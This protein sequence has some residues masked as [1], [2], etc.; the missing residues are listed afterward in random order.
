M[1]TETIQNDVELNETKTVPIKDLYDL[2]EQGLGEYEILTPDGFKPIGDVYKKTNKKIYQLELSNGMVLKGSSDHLVLIDTSRQSDENI[3]SNVELRDNNTWIRLQF[4]TENEFV[5]TENGVF[6]VSDITYIGNDD[7]F[8]LEVLTTEHSYISNGIVSHNT[9]KSAI[10]EGLAIR[11]I[12]KK[13]P[14][15][16]FDKRI[17]SLDLGTIVAGTK[18]RG[19]FE[20]RMKAI[21]DELV[22]NP[23][24]ILFIDEI[25]T[26]VGAGGTSGSLDAANMV[27]PALARGELQCIGATTIDE[28][29]ENIEKDGAL[30]RRFQKVDIDPTS[31]EDTYTIL[32]N[33]KGIYEDHHNV[34]YTDESLMACVKLSTRYITDRNLPDKAIDAMDEAGSRVNIS[35]VVVPKKITDLEEKID[36]LNI[37]KKEVVKKQR[38]EDAAKIRDN[39][40]TLKEELEAAKEEW[41][42]SLKDNKKTVNESDI[43]E[44]ISMVTGIPLKKV[45]SEEDDTLNKLS[46]RLKAKVVGQDKAIEKVSLAIKRSRIGLKDPNKPIGTFI[47]AGVSGSGKTQLS[48]AIAEELFEGRDSLIRVDMSEY[49]ER[50]AVSRLIGAP[51]GYVGH[52][53]GGKLTEAVRRKPYSVVL[54]DEIEK[55]HPDVFN[56]LLQV[57]DEGHLTDSLGRKV[58]FKNTIIIMTSNIGIKT[59]S[60]FGDGIGFNTDIKMSQ[61]EKNANKVIEKEM[62]KKFAPEFL[63]RID[64]IIIFNELQKSHLNEIVKIELKHVEDRINELG[65]TFT[66]RKK[67]IEFIAERGYNPEYGARPLKRAIQRYVEDPIAEYLVANNLKE[68]KITI[69]YNKGDEELSLDI[70]P[71][72]S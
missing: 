6:K 1:T 59:L 54:L 27:K 53:E 51:P 26:I 72:V 55:A 12:E 11:I 37:E 52:E 14:R 5:V 31:E 28:Y 69:N 15:V 22:N 19:E 24:I 46:D 70:K 60:Q 35:N 63:N 62:K 58:D 30:V 39:E 9:G 16:L 4:I 41:E 47:M 61:K 50:F 44:V 38:Y 66:I 43:S 68:G 65:F 45:D 18:Y 57:L 17:V 33:I 2:V 34:E 21:I 40:R 8:D 48:K 67:A 36:Q 25:H 56:L 71:K 20:Q 29:R 49:M 32:Q 42:Q 13:V 23:D 3:N 64:D 7:T 10:A